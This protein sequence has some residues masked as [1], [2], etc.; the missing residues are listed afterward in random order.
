VKNYYVILPIAG[1]ITVTVEAENEKDAIQK[2]LETDVSVNDIDEWQTMEKFHSG[3]V[4][5]CP[6]PW[7]AT[8]E[9]CDG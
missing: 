2:A 4:C 1:H 7:E 6:S 5:H 9:E 3:N 8:A